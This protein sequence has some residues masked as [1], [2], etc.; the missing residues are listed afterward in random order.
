LWL[1]AKF[2]KLFRRY[3]S[4]EEAARIINWLLGP[5]VIRD[6]KL[7]SYYSMNISEH[8]YIMDMLIDYLSP[9]IRDQIINIDDTNIIYKI[10]F[11]IDEKV[12]ILF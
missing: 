7:P 10:D 11:N 5:A 8:S 9:L 1:A 6:I 4:V 2:K 3:E 12:S